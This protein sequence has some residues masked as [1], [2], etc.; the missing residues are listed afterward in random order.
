MIG[1]RSSANHIIA[2]VMKNANGIGESKSQAKNNSNIKGQNGH[3]VSSKAH[4]IKSTENLR[5]V[6]TQYVNF[7]KENYDGKV[8]GNL[9]NDT[10]KHFMDTKSAQVSGGTLNSYIS[11]MGKVAD[12]LNQLGVNNISRDNITD[13]RKELKENGT[14]LKNEHTNRAYENAE[15]IVNEVNNNSSYGLSAQLQYEA[16]LRAD[17]ATNSSKW[18]VNPDGSLHVS[19]SKNGLNYDTRPLSDDLRE[20]V[21]LAIQNNY[22]ADYDAYREAIKEATGEDYTGT[23]GLRYSYA[24]ERMAELQ[25]SGTD[26][27]E[28]LSQTSLEMGHSRE[29]ITGHYLG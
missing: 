9:N 3:N 27:N 12:N 6:T 8:A 13:Y 4:S 28:A 23:H 14:E 25:E 29:E 22:K 2:E 16:G 5:S 21:E 1:K 18:S 17:D 15:R 24:Q 26:Y 11:T 20:K 10:A 19:G 7:V